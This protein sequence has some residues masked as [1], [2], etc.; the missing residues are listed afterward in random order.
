M[1]LP[2]VLAPKSPGDLIRSDDWNA[3][4]A[5]VNAIESAINGRLDALE[6]D[7]ATLTGR[8]GAVEGEVAALRDAI[9][10]LFRETYRVTLRTTR[11]AFAMGEV[12]ELTAELRNLR[13]EVPV[14]VDGE[15]PW[16]D[17]VTTW[18]QLKAVPGF[19]SRAGV[20]ERTISV[21]A[22]A[23]GV[24][25]VR[26]AAEIVADM[27]D[28]T[29]QEFQ[30]VV[31]RVVGAGNRRIADIILEANTPADEP[32]RHAYQAM[33]LSYDAVANTA[34]RNYVDTYYARNTATLAGRLAPALVN[35]RRERWRD[36][37]ATVMAFAK[38]DADPRTPDHSR[39]VNAIQVT[40]RDWLGP[41]ILLDYFPRFRDLVPLAVD[42]LRP[43]VGIDYRGSL[44]RMKDVV[45][46]RFVPLGALGKAREFEV[47]RHAIDVLDVPQREFLPELRQSMKSAVTLQ[48]TVQQ[49][50]FAVLGGGF[51][52]AAFE[53]FAN[54]AAKADSQVVDV[55]TQVRALT[56]QVEEVQAQAQQ[57]VATV[58][59]NVRA[60]DGRLEATLAEGGQLR[61]VQQQL[62]VVNDQVQA[63]RMLGDPSQVNQSLQMIG[64][65]DARI[66]M[67]ERGR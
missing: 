60:L 3:L 25:R 9:E 35:Q 54:T 33:T 5:G 48:Q 19:T 39:G 41:W 53:A 14:P 56:W 31:D 28:D 1:P 55:G 49:A 64:A 12:A 61:Q 7:V 6:A 8:V 57:Q 36:S 67:L 10:P 2:N 20:A 52:E 59:Q 34:V 50:Q 62:Q 51:E 23:E 38:A 15:R 42:R 46:Q 47:L 29:E 58:Q 37:H 11:V 45:R 32:V 18:G 27:T 26:L 43:T 63:L 16:V 30:A 40:F 4:V 24:A 66:A 65:F 17:F 13:G 21:Q 22:N 44:D